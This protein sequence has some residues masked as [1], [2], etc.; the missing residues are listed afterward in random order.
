MFFKNTYLFICLCQVLVVACKIFAVHRL[1]FS[2]AVAHRLQSSWA[3]Q[4]CHTGFVAPTACG[5][6]VSWPWIKPMS[7]CVARQILNSWTTREVSGLHTVWLCWALLFLDPESSS[8]LR[9]LYRLTHILSNFLGNGD[10]EANLL[11]P[12]VDPLLEVNS[13]FSSSSKNTD[14]VYGLMLNY[15]LCFISLN[16]PLLLGT[17]I[18]TYLY[19]K[20]KWKWSRSVMSDS[21]QPHGL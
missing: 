10:W 2:L 12:H 9:N 20:Q 15:L 17:S 16:I 14:F 6:L 3:Q 21:L 5:I 8:F 11:S 1:L 19:T 4:L 7:P 18:P 13:A